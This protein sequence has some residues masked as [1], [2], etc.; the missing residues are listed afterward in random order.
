MR[1]SQ[2]VNKHRQILTVKSPQEGERTLE[3]FKKLAEDAPPSTI[4]DKAPLGGLLFVDGT[5][6]THLDGNRLDLAVWD[7]DT[8][9]NI[10]ETGT[11]DPYMKY[12][13]GGSAIENYGWGK[14]IDDETVRLVQLL[15]WLDN[16]L[17]SAL[18]RGIKK[19]E[20]DWNGAYPD[21][22]VQT[23]KAM[24]AQTYMH[25]TTA[26]DTLQHYK[27]DT[28]NVCEYDFK[29]DTVEDFLDTVVTGIL[30][31]IGLLVN[32][33]ATV[34]KNDPWFVPS[35]ATSLGSK[36]RMSGVLNMM[37]SH[38]AAAAPREVSLPPGL[39][40][41]YAHNEWVKSC[42]SDIEGF[43]DLPALNIEDVKK[44]QASG[45]TT[46]FKLKSDGNEEGGWAAFI[47]AWGKVYSEKV[48]YDGKVEVPGDLHGHVWVVLTSEDEVDGQDLYNVT[49]AGPAMVWLD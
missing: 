16:I 37:Q 36:S 15:Q 29:M 44:D 1:K 49:V 34:A 25:R 35:L 22:I 23:L 46:S 39:V 5:L 6:I 9:E 26:T 38:M 48:S 4:Q 32:V 47:G 33:L 20:G 3:A 19:F 12:Q 17:L 27:K 14:T 13:A 24:T 28:L 42:P 2:S 41:A 8:L 7:D 40:Y 10:P 18:M 30:L 21:A 31:E 11:M 43:E 45:K